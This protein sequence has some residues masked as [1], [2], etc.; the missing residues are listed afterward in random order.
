MCIRDRSKFLRGEIKVKGIH[1]IVQATTERFS[2]RKAPRSV[3][4]ISYFIKEIE[5]IAV[6]Q[7]SGDKK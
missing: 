4:E 7:I 1:K 6:Q 2:G 5:E 3:E